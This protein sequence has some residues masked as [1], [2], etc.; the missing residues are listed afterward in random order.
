MDD[1]L[2]SLLDLQAHDICFLELSNQLKAVPIGIDGLLA[3]MAT[4]KATFSE[5]ETLYQ[6]KEVRRREVDLKIA[7]QEELI[8][9][10]KTQQISVKKNEEYSALEHQI[11]AVRQEMSVLEEEGIV[12]LMNLDEAR[13]QLA[14]AAAQYKDK[15]AQLNEE[16]ETL[17][18]SESVLKVKVAAA[19]QVYQAAL[20]LLLPDMRERYE[21][22]KKRVTRPPFVVILKDHRCQGCFLKLSQEVEG[23]V[24]T[25]GYASC[26]QCGRLIYTAAV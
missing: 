26:D 3:K 25:V 23:A 14:E 8:V 20:A 15:T 13:A 4:L 24:L 11:T 21:W 1:A 6:S 12:L 2:S 18:A 19:E 22:V 9:R 10:Y 17:K 16:L 5:A 7:S